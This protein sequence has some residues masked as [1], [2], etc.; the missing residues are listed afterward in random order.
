[1][2]IRLVTTQ[3]LK[4]THWPP[5]LRCLTRS[6]DVRKACS[7]SATRG[8]AAHWTEAGQGSWR[9]HSI[10][11]ASHTC[12]TIRRSDTAR[13]KPKRRANGISIQRDTTRRIIIGGFVG[14]LAMEG[15]FLVLYFV[16]RS[17]FEAATWTGIFPLYV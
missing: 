11:P 8:V 1:M 13:Q 4:I 15:G 2:P 7:L 10:I 17:S 9:W 12:W 14:L 6:V 3:T 16:F 5:F